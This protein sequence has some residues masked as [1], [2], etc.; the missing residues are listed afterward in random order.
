MLLWIVVAIPW[1]LS[2]ETRD[3]PCERRPEESLIPRRSYIV[4]SQAASTI[5]YTIDNLVV[6]LTKP[7]PKCSS[8]SAPSAPISCCRVNIVSGDTAIEPVGT[9]RLADMSVTWSVVSALILS[10]GWCGYYVAVAKQEEQSRFQT[11]IEMPSLGDI[12]AALYHLGRS[13]LA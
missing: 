3:G 1:E 7:A 10:V 11:K 13:L 6:C 2:M 5:T 8:Q 9:V 12:L 4:V